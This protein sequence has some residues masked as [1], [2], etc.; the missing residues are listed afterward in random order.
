MSVECA[1]G[2][3]WRAVALCTR[4]FCGPGHAKLDLYKNGFVNLAL[5]FFG[6][7]EPIAPEKKKYYEKEWTLWDRFEIQGELTVG[8]L[9]QYF[10]K[11][12]KL[13]VTMLSQGLCLLYSFFMPKEKREKTFAANVRF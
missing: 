11:D 8:Q 4:L 6:F 3:A 12:L 2:A 13:E 1:F 5:P 10:E 9:L 7:S